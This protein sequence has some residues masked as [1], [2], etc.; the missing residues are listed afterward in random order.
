[1][2]SGGVAAGGDYMATAATVA[3]IKYAYMV[4]TPI[5]PDFTR[6]PAA[7]PVPRWYDNY[8]G[9]MGTSV[10]AT[11]AVLF[12]GFISSSD[13]GNYSLT[14]YT[15]DGTIIP[16]SSADVGYGRKKYVYRVTHASSPDTGNL[17]ILR[18]V[19]YDGYYARGGIHEVMALSSVVTAPELAQLDEY[20]QSYWLSGP[21]IIITGDSIS[22][23][24][25]I[26]ESQGPAALIWEAYDGSIDCPSIAIPGQG[27]TSSVV[28]TTQTMTINDPA[29][30]AAI[31]GRHSN[32][33]VALAGTNDL[34]QGR[35]AAQLFAD[36]QAYTAAAQ[37]L[38]H[39][40]IVGTIA[41]RSDGIWSG[42]AEIQRVAYN[43]LISASHAWANGFVDVAAKAP[44]LQGDNVH[45][46]AASTADVYTGTNGVKSVIDTLI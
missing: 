26:T 13:W 1:M 28:T 35:T 24:Y 16:A 43:S 8:H 42:A 46:T 41:A 31:A 23:G 15:R 2:G 40:V 14:E 7:D 37:A 12:T 36:L 10:I 30:I 27:V 11:S 19:G 22:A 6:G 29:R 3:G 18:H 25:G 39:R 32:I 17:N 4:A 9:F 44:A 20:F 5:G 33:I 34:G 21:Q 45:W 38:G